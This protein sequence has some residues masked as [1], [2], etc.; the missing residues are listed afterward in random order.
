MSDPIAN[1]AA[2]AVTAAP[3]ASKNTPQVE[4]ETVE[5]LTEK[6]AKYKDIAKTQETRAKENAAAAKE[7]A[8]IRESQKTE[9][10]KI[11]DRLAK[12]DAET[13]SIP[14][15]VA[16][17]LKAHLV[18]LH[19][20]DA[21]DA[22]LFLTATEPELLLKQIARLVSQSDTQSK[23]NHVPS[24]GRNSRAPHALNGDGLEQAL[25]AK[26]GISN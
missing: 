9:A 12:A 21:E 6:L 22:E 1:P 4:A 23:S 11:A 8:D 2:A 26:L 20:I 10:Q 18:G 16:D 19:E 24:E 25:K 5:T 14:A 17:A 13:A 15:K 7:L 3:D